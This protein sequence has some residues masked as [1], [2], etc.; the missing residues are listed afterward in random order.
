MAKIM[1]KLQPRA[2]KTSPKKTSP[3]KRTVASPVKS[4]TTAQPKQRFNVNHFR[5]EDF[6]T[7]GLRS[8]AQYRDLGMSK[9]TNG[10][11]Q[12]HVIRLIPPCDPAVVSKR[13]YH[14]VHV[15]MIYVLKGWIR[16]EFEGQGEVTMRAGTAWLQPPRIEHTVLD[17]SDDCE[18]LEIILPAEF[19]TVELQ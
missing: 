11:L 4:K 16:S 12:A 6:R 9:A 15:Q 13:H 5:A 14:D 18:L 1:A 8:Y 19:E 17:Y 7:D 3:K 2:R 10:L